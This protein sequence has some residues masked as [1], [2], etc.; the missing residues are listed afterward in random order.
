MLSSGEG[1]E[2]KKQLQVRELL[3]RIVETADRV[4]GSEDIISKAT[5]SL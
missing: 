4:R 2:K 1:E 5:N 3:Q